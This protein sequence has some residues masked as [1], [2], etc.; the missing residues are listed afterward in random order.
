M[1]YWGWGIIVVIHLEY[2][3]YKYWATQNAVMRYIWLTQLALLP[4]LSLCCA[5]F[6]FC[7]LNLE[8][9]NF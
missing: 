7:L 2:A 1:I 8:D 9:A 4:A 6:P 5:K 3:G